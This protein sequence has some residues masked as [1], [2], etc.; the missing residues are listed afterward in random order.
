MIEKNDNSD[1]V[2]VK[3]DFLQRK[4]KNFEKNIFQLHR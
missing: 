1:V 3:N 4:N 2:V